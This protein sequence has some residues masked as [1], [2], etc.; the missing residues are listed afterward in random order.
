MFWYSHLFQ[1]VPVCCDPHKGVSIVNEAEVD[2]FLDF[3]AFSKVQQ[4]LAI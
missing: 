3:L 1:D 2:F 4:M